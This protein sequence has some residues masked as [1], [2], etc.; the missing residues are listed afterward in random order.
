MNFEEYQNLTIG[1]THHATSCSVSI[2]LKVSKYVKKV[3]C[4]LADR[5]IGLTHHAPSGSIIAFLGVGKGAKIC[6]RWLR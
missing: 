5:T 1:L 3:I 4:L 6:G 2:L